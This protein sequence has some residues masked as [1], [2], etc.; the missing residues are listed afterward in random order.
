MPP[1]RFERAFGVSALEEKA[2]AQRHPGVEIHFYTV[3]RALLGNGHHAVE[4]CGANPD[5]QRTAESIAAA[6]SSAPQPVAQRFRDAYS[7]LSRS[8]QAWRTLTLPSYRWSLLTTKPIPGYPYA[9]EHIGRH[10][11]KRRL[12]LGLTPRTASERFGLT[13][14]LRH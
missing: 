6:H 7:S 3:V 12:A 11:I 9:L 14:V 4:N 10:L 13:L 5:A 2:A 1:N 8:S